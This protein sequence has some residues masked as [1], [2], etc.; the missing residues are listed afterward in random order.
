MGSRSC[1]RG[2]RRASRST[3][4][5]GCANPQSQI[6]DHLTVI[7]TNPALGA[8]VIATAGSAEKLEV[9][10]RYGGADEVLNYRDDGW[11]KAVM[12]ITGGRGV[13]E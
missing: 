5:Q 13:G 2:R 12:K 9:C 3:D 8:K 7:A 1:W 6:Y 11:Q 10:K 4:R